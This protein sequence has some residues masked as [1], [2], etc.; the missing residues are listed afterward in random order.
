M[1]NS[2]NKLVSRDLALA[3]GY[4]FSSARTLGTLLRSRRKR[5]GYTQEDVAAMLGYS[6]R[7]IGE[8]ERGRGSVG[9]DRVMLYATNLGVDFAAF[10]R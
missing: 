8:I 10:E 6:P 2:P 9:F 5:L 4:P 3:S 7:L 1:Q